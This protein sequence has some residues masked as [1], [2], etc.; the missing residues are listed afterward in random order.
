MGASSRAGWALSESGGTKKEAS[1]P[2]QERTL[3]HPKEGIAQNRRAWKDGN[4]WLGL[5]RDPCRV[6]GGHEMES[7][8]KYPHQQRQEPPEK[9]LAK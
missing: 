1:I 6:K 4:F 2:Q 7:V 5:A 3:V 8:L 9:N